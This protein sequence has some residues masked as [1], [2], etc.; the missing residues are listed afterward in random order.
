MSETWPA[1]TPADPTVPGAP[2]RPPRP[3]TREE[4]RRVDQRATDEMGMPSLLLMENA[5][6]G[7][8]DVVARELRAQAP[9]SG[10][11]AAVIVCGRGNN[12]GDGLVLARHLELRG[13]APRVAYAGRRAEADRGGDAGVNLTIVERAGLPIEEAPDAQALRGLLARWDDAVLLVDALFGTGLSEPLRDPG[14]S[15]VR[16]LD[17][18]PRPK[19]AVDVPSGL[20]CDRGLPLGA[21]VRA[22]LTVTFVGEKV[23]FRAGREFTGEVEVVGIGCP[24]VCW[25]HVGA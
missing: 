8:A 11:P 25:S 24:A 13:Y 18:D 21:A 19:V 3:L 20:D 1:R 10:R 4:V 12:G 15:L 16:A 22:A 7:L 14:L 23:G 5:G 9:G 17:A 6:L 2:A